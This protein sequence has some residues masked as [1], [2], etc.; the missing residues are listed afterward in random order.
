MVCTHNGCAWET[1]RD[2]RFTQ[3]LLQAL[4]AM[5][6]DIF[7]SGKAVVDKARTAYMEGIGS[8]DVIFC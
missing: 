1:G 5:K 2:Q 7:R 8:E 3:Q 4:A 6:Q